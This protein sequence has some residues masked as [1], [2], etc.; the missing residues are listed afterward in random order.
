MN[1]GRA[2][3][4]DAIRFGILHCG[5]RHIRMFDLY[6][7]LLVVLELECHLWVR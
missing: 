2:K 1:V 3:E 5:K 4:G 7:V 6:F